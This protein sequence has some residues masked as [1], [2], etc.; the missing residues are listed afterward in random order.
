[1]LGFLALS[2]ALPGQ[3]APAPDVLV[4]KDGEKLVGRVE[5]SVGGSLKFRSDS[6]GS[7]TVE[8]NKVKEL[9][10]TRRFAVVPKNV[11]LRLPRDAGQIVTGTLSMNNQKLQ[12]S[13]T[14]Q[15]IVAVSDVSHVIDEGDFHKAEENKDGL[16][17]GWSGAVTGGAALVQATEDSRSF[18]AA[19]NLIQP[20]PAEDW[21]A[22]RYRTTV[23][24]NAVYGKETQSGVPDVITSIEH[25]DAER[26]FYF[27]PRWFG[28]GQAALDHNF[29]QGLHLQQ[30]Y[31]GGAGWIA[32][33]SAKQELDLKAGASYVRQDLA[34]IADINLAGATF[35]ETFNRKLTHGML[36]N[37]DLSVVEPVNHPSDYTGQA[38]LRFTMPVY[39]R[40]NLTAGTVDNFLNDPP[41]GFRKN[42]FQIT[43]GVTYTLK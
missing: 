40:L 25:F 23:D 2:S 19:V 35:A 15:Q 41:P 42:S 13:G 43:T 33:K 7:V 16:L 22:P 14:T 32:A 17:H 6:F 24:F 5:N 10:T 37:E 21:L 3:T 26:D 30:N 20:V 12:I 27:N 36:I 34:G 11:T 29:A 9:Q 28:F 31:G 4:L 18:N 1:V 39:K 8:W 38:S